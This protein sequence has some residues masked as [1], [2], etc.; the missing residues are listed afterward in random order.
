MIDATVLR[1]DTILI[2][3]NANFGEINA[4]Y[5]ICPSDHHDFGRVQNKR[6]IQTRFEFLGWPAY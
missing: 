3:P 2:F 4:R 6:E 1:G 5:S